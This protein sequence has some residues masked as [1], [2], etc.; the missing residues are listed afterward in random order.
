MLSFYIPCKKI[1]LAANKIF[2][3][4]SSEHV[5]KPTLSKEYPR[6]GVFFDIE[7]WMLEL[8]NNCPDNKFMISFNYDS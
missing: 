2:P 1:T 6:N 5:T 4:K 7:T 8:L 3:V